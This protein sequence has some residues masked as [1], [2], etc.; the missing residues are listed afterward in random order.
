MLFKYDLEATSPPSPQTI[1]QDPDSEMRNSSPPT[2]DLR[3][4]SFLQGSSATSKLVSESVGNVKW[5]LGATY[6]F[7]GKTGLFIN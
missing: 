6:G 7:M 2:L 1:P 5:A 4:S 3:G